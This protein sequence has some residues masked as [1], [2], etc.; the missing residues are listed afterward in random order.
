MRKKVQNNGDYNNTYV[1]ST[2]GLGSEGLI[3]R[4]GYWKY[5]KDNAFKKHWG[6]V[7]HNGNWYYVNAGNVDFTVTSITQYNGNLFYLS[8]GKA[9]GEMLLLTN[10]LKIPKV[11]V[12]PV[13]TACYCKI[14]GY[15]K[16]EPG[17]I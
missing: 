4:D 1:S 11:G 10:G 15:P 14:N 16:T 6:I 2:K 13:Q 3:Y 9:D 17:I 7:Y 8:N 5:Y 12:M